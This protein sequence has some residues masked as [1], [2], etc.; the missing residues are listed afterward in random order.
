MKRLRFADTLGVLDPFSTREKIAR[1]RAGTAMEIEMHAHNDL[2]LATA[3][4]L[5][6]FDAGAT[7]ANTTI[8]GLGERAGNAPLE[9]VAVALHVLKKG[10]SGIDLAQ[11]PGVC[12]YT[13]R[14][15]GRQTSHRKPLRERWCLP[16][17]LGS[18]SMV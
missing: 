18:M 12:G 5:A 1:L 8:N 6:A 14:V 16:M 15:S 9:E 7:S 4:T 13:S 10:V 11:L 3:N 17:S 2:G